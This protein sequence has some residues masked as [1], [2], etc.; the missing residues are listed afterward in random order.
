VRAPFRIVGTGGQTILSVTES[1]TAAGKLEM[2]S[3]NGKSFT[4]GMTPEG[5]PFA[6]WDA[7]NGSVAIGAPPGKF[8]GVRVIPAGSDVSSVSLLTSNNIA[9][10]MVGR[11]GVPRLAMVDSDAN[12]S[13]G[14]LNSAGQYLSRLTSKPSGGGLEVANGTGQ[15]VAILDS[16]PANNE[17]R[18]SFYNASGTPLAKIG[19]AGDHGD[20]LL[21]GPN[22]TVAVWEMALTGMLR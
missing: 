4:A 19:A 10:V 1:G 3:T 8:F 9:S 7:T 5:I 15:M 11:S 13:I 21:G 2:K 6:R 18:A 20:V 14:I 12:L 17:G 16:N 22:K